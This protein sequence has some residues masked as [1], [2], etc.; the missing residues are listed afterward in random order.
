MTTDEAPNDATRSVSL[1]RIGK[2]RY[3]ATNARG[4]VLPIGM[5]EDPDFTP[6]EL[7]LAAIAGCSSIDVDL[8][9]GKRAQPLDFRVSASG[10]KVRDEDGNHMT[11]LRVEFSITF[12]E[13]P[14]GDRARDFLPR[15]IE[16]SRDRLCTVSRTVSLG[17]PVEFVQGTS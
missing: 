10:E 8:I 9:T 12:P 17:S 13:G 2:G 11:D 7:L 15:A 1:E 4:G 5:G 14:D 6:V 16:Q 3:K